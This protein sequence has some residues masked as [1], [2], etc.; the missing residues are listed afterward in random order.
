MVHLKHKVEEGDGLAQELQ[1]R[2][3]SVNQE[4]VHLAAVMRQMAPHLKNIFVAGK[5]EPADQWIAKMLDH[6]NGNDGILPGLWGVSEESVE[7]WDL[8]ETFQMRCRR[9]VQHSKASDQSASQLRLLLYW[10]FQDSRAALD[11]K[12]AEE[13]QPWVE[14]VKLLRQL[15]GEYNVLDP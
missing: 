14:M 10:L 4:L 3:K 2:V 5:A 9:F 1:K 6:L 11:G 8:L 15:S 7:A 13:K 12:R